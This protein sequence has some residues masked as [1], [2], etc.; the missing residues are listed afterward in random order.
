MLI[1]LNHNQLYYNHFLL[2]HNLIDPF[3]SFK[4][5]RSASD[6]AK[7]LPFTLIS[8]RKVKQNKKRFPHVRCCQIHAACLLA[9]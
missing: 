4:Q 8:V 5:H 7:R 2:L 6:S 3:S 9:F 1:W